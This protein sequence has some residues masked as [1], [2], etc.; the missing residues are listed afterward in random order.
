MTKRQQVIA[1][2]ALGW[3]FRRI[4]RETKV[5][6]ET[7]SRYARPAD[8]NP[9]KV[10]PGSEGLAGGEVQDSP[11]VEGPNAAKVTAGPWANAAKVFPGSSLAAALGGGEVRGDDPGEARPGAD[12]A[13]DLAGPGRGLRL[14]VQLRVGEALRA[15]ARARAASGG[16]DDEPA[17]GG[18]A[19]GLLPGAAD[20]GRSQR[21][22]ASAV[23]LPD[24]AVPL[25]PR[26][27]GGGVG[28]EARELPGS[29]RAGLP[30]PWR[31]APRSS[32]TTT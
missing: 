4:E 20:A 7:V 16:R 23:D 25:A 32:V 5:R 22:V 3:S 18:S 9:A 12:G 28:P 1:L 6:R 17:R 24:D 14:R 19:G 2:L 31:R 21:A 26:V 10:F 11:G 30:R 15:A 27:R 13:A 8:P 29:S